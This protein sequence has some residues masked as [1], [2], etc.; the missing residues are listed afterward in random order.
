MGFAKAAR[1]CS[2]YALG[3]RRKVRFLTL[4]QLVMRLRAAAFEGRLEYCLAGFCSL[5]LLV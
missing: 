4:S 2:Q 1:Q 5:E 3:K